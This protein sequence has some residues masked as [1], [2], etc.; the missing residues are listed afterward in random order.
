MCGQT[1]VVPKDIGG[2][3]NVFDFVHNISYVTAMS[4]MFSKVTSPSWPGEPQPLEPLT[5][6]TSLQFLL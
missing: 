3:P 5:S 4:T 1:Y 6:Q 2:S